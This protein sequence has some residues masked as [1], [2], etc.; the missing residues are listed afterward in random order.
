[1]Y[2]EKITCY[3]Q[4][5]HGASLAILTMWHGHSKIESILTK[6]ISNIVTILRIRVLHYKNEQAGDEL[7]QT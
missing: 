7:G 5:F 4:T 2:Y 6:M 3:V 1:M